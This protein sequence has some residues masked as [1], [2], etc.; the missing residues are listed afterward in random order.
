MVAS[1]SNHEEP[2][3]QERQ[4]ALLRPHDARSTPQTVLVSL[5]AS[6]SLHDLGAGTCRT[7]GRLVCLGRSGS[8]VRFHRAR[9]FLLNPID[10]PF[11]PVLGA[12][13]RIVPPSFPS[14]TRD[15]VDQSPS[16]RT[17]HVST[18]G[19]G[20]ESLLPRRHRILSIRRFQASSRPRVLLEADHPAEE[21]PGC[22]SDTSSNLRE[23]RLLVSEALRLAS[24][25]WPPRCTRHRIH[26]DPGADAKP[27]HRDVAWGHPSVR[28]DRL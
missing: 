6:P 19:L 21:R 5:T 23:I 3:R 7:V 11:E 20:F 17:V 14:P 13:I 9:K 18:F 15:L 10:V 22:R 1:C 28:W 2:H 24:R 27:R 12:W 26:A 25:A 4:E 8:Y 16:H